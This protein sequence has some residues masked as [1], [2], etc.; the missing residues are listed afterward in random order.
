VKK[1]L[2]RLALRARKTFSSKA[3]VHVLSTQRFEQH[4]ELERRLLADSASREVA[5]D[6]SLVAEGVVFSKDR[7]LQLHLLL[8]SYFEMVAH[9]AP[10]HVLYATSAPEY[11]RAYEELVDEMRETP[12]RFVREER[13]RPTL[14]RTMAALRAPRVFFLVD[15]DVFIDRFDLASLAAID[16]R[17]HIVSLRLAPHVR[18]SYMNDL[19]QTVPSFEPFA[20]GLLRFRW[21][22][23]GL[24]WSYPMSVDGHV[25]DRA[26]LAVLTRV[27][28]YKAP[29]TFEGALA[30]LGALFATRSGLCFER[31]K[32]VNLPANKVQT[33][34]AN[35]AG[36]RDVGE[37][38][39]LW[40]HG[41]VIDPA[42]MYGRKNVS[43]H[44][45]WELPVRPRAALRT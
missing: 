41:C 12:V 25:F 3:G 32:I 10:L 30:E 37:L 2:T 29:N 16:P 15:D 39:E 35:R 9:A 4:L 34:N 21:G 27:L 45:D 24:D 33:E 14:T 26:E 1:A 6:A 7:P 42:P 20:G 11:T 43:A 19:E 13:F 31:S 8:T 36:E 17:E 5:S 44:E 40:N 18:Y 23:G 38:L 22:E 28:D